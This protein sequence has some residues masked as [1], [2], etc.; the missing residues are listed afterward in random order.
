VKAL[1]SILTASLLALALVAVNASAQEGPKFEFHG[2]VVGTLYVQDQ[3]FLA[4]QGS[5]LLISA[6]APANHLK[7][8]GVATDKTGMFLGGDARQTR[9]IFVLT[10]PKAFGA[11][12]KAWLEFDLFGNSNAGALGYESANLRLRQAYGEL[13]W[14]NTTVDVGQHSAQLILAFIP[15]TLAHITNPV[16]FGAGLYGWRTI[17]V[18]AMHAIP[19]DSMKLTLA[20]ELSHGKWNDQ[21]ANVAM[22]GNAPNAIS[23]AWASNMPQ[24]VA[25]V[26]ADGKS[27]NLTWMGWVAGSYESVNLKGFGDTNVNAGAAGVVL[28]DGSRKTSLGSYAVTAGTQLTFMPVTLKAQLSTGRGTAPM[29]GSMLQFGDINDLGYWAQLGFYATPQVSIWAI[30][31]ASTLDKKDLQNWANPGGTVLTEA[32]TG[33]RQANAVYGGM[34][35][36]ADAG[37]AYGLEYYAN[38]TDWLLGTLNAPAGTKNTTAYQILLS[39]GYFF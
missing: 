12:P 27:G 24:I 31:G 4:G 9:P 32:N 22:P 13:K 36:F 33:L 2:F 35:K 34:L 3:V 10:G 1:R 21:V 17:G 8:P 11:T 25:R 38:S 6:P 7:R 5:G 16:T 26:M 29:A 28:Q 19:M 18:R 20:A 37:Y 39:G 15:D 14:G 23:L 30:Y